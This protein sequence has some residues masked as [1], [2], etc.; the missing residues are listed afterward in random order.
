MILGYNWIK[1]PNK[2]QDRCLNSRI[3]ERF[4]LGVRQY[5]AARAD[6]KMKWRWKELY[7]ASVLLIEGW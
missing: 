6:S 1:I 3:V 2:M 4:V 5:E 7:T